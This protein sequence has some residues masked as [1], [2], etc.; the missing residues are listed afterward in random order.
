MS[1]TV[2]YVASYMWS[3]L[4]FDVFTVSETSVFHSRLSLFPRSFWLAIWR[5]GSALV[6]INEVSLRRARLVLRWVTVSG[7]SS[8]CRTFIWACNQ[9]PRPTQSSILRGSV[10]EDQPRLGRQR[11]VWFIPLADERGVCTVQVKL[12]DLLGTRAIPERLR[13]VFTMRRCTNARVPFTLP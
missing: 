5:S 6:W 13:G 7:F 10:N 9:P 11:Q 1:I 4:D 2:K 3:L 8:R 12:W